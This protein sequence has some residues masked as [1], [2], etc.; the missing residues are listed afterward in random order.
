MEIIQNIWTA[1]TTEN[2]S[3][4]QIITFPLAILE[5]LLTMFLF[6][7]IFDIK[8][9]TKQKIIYI[10]SFML[11]GMLANAIIPVPY[12]TFINLLSCFVLI[13]VVFKV[14]PTNSIFSFCNCWNL[15]T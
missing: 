2:I 6:L 9:N 15:S 13:I 14:G 7:R 5:T 4:T 8:S 11:I 1:L 10:V 12:N 3:L